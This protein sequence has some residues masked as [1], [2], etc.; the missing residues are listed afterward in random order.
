MTTPLL[1]TADGAEDGQ[2]R[3]RRRLA[4]R[5]RSCRATTS[6]NTGATPT[7]AT[8]A[9]SCACSPT[10]RSTRSPGSKRSRAP[11]STQA[12]IVLANEVTRLVPRRGSRA[13]RRSDRGRHVRRRR[14]ARIC[15]C[16]R[17]ARGHDHRRAP[18]PRSASPPRTAR[19]SA[20]SPRARCGSTT[21]PVTDPSA[22][23]RLA[24]AKL[25]PRQ[26]E[27]RDPARRPDGRRLYSLF[28]ISCDWRP[29]SRG[30]EGGHQVW[31]AELSC[32]SPTCAA[33]RGTRSIT[34]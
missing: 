33:P 8:S 3:G 29:S 25:Q 22:A 21:Q 19:P 6:G 9:A 32:P 24:P 26:E 1:T 2:D 34:R 4:Q 18:A 23:G 28:S 5:G 27:T 15:R 16:S 7:T 12:K 10:C 17:A 31:Q 14:S 20:R 30:R 13:H 11:R